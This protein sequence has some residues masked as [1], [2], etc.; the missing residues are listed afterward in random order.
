MANLNGFNA[1]NVE[2]ATDFDPIPAAKYLA[3]ITNSEFKPTK[4]NSGNYLELTFQVI[5]GQY[6]N[7]LLWAR[8][9]LE[10]PNETTAKISRGQLSAVCK[11]VGVMTPKDS[12]ELHNLP[13]LIN[14]K[15]K[16]RN[17]TGELTNEIKGFSSRETSPAQN[18]TPAAKG[19]A[20]WKR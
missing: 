20:P 16:K 1:N 5:E 18:S 8:L 11:S 3:V 10:H 17:D 2:P 12:A 19:I 7:R 4:N 13:L 15:L 14:V 6:K 9:N